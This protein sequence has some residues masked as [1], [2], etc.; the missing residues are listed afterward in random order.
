VSREYNRFVLA[1]MERD[2][3]KRMLAWDARRD[4]CSRWEQNVFDIAVDNGF[5]LRNH[6]ERSDLEREILE[7][8]LF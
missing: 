2:K 5:A 8:D 3:V 4:G 7:E 6:K 1:N